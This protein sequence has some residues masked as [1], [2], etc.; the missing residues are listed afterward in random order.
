MNFKKIL[1]TALSLF[2]FS[3]FNSL[4]AQSCSSATTLTAANGTFNDGSAAILDYSNNQNCQ[5]LI[6][7]TGATIIRL[8]FNRFDT[9]DCCDAIKIYDGTNTSAPRI[10]TF[11]G[12]TIPSTITATGGSLF[13]V[14]TTDGSVTSTG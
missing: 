11:K 2:I 6:Q 5:W 9:E 8:N 7:P 13:V 10:G 3:I 1:I 14:F 12:T 4:Q